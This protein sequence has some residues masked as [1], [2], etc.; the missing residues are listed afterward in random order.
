MA[1]FAVVCNW[2]AFAP[3]VVYYS[4]GMPYE[5]STIEIQLGGRIVFGIT[6]L[7]VDYTLI[8]T[9]VSWVRSFRE[10]SEKRDDL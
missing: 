9:M 4:D 1:L 2:T 6:A 8:A 10:N 5:F 7:I 3:G